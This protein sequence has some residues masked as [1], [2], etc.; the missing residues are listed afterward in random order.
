MGYNLKIILKYSDGRGQVGKRGPYG[1][2]VWGY[3]PN[4]KFNKLFN[5]QKT[6]MRVLFV[7]GKIS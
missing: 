1:I 3:I 5:A 2:T 7:K 6:I 4:Q